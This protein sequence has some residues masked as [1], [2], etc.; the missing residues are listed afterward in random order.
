MSTTRPRAST[1]AARERGRTTMADRVVRRVAQ[2]AAT[3]ALPAGNVG[4]TDAMV[5]TRSGRARVSV[6]LALPYQAALEESGKRVQQHVAERT[7]A[8][9]GLMV[10]Q[11][12]V[13]VCA[14][15]LP[16]RTGARAAAPS[17][18]TTRTQGSAAGRAVR[19]WSERRVLSALAA[20]LGT[21][22][23]TLLLHD[24]AFLR[25]AGGESALWRSVLLKWL[26][27]H[28]PRDFTLVMCTAMTL[29]GIGM[30][31]VAVL[32]GRRRLFAI[33]PDV[34]GVRSTLDQASAG[35]LMHQAVLSVPGVSRVRVRVG[36]R[37]ARVRARVEFGDPD[38][39]HRAV[40]TAANHV[41][42]TY[43]LGRPPRLR[44]RLGTAAG[45]QASHRP[46]GHRARK[47]GAKAE[48]K[49]S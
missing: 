22:I 3:E 30:V 44:V 16:D 45:L 21:T 9:T 26:F 31:L 23:C 11:P 5:R 46:M 36:R 28:G 29:L 13:R 4:F 39:A 49:S 27:T 48:R 35:Q 7:A 42:A 40:V 6:E 1:V 24:F 12:R 20:L 33:R 14:L 47:Q 15:T 37:R 41:L 19:T 43:G 25:A 34:E 32:P 17:A 18:M 38:A 8:L 2:R 10:S